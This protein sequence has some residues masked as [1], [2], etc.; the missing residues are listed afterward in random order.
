[1]QRRPRVY[2]IATY[3]NFP[4]S[5]PSPSSEIG[6]IDSRLLLY[7]PDWARRM[8][9]AALLL[10]FALSAFFCAYLLINRTDGEGPDLLVFVLSV[11]QASAAG[12]VFVLILFY[13][14]RDANIDTLVAHSDEFLKKHMRKALERVSVPDLRIERF[15]VRDGGAKDVFGHLF[16]MEAGELRVPVWIGLNV[17]RLFVIYYLAREERADFTARV[18]EIFR[19]TF[20]GA[21]QAGFTANCEEAVVSGEPVLSIWLCADTHRDLLTNPSEKLFWSQDVAM[22]TESFVRTALRNGLNLRTRCNPA[23]L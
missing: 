6:G 17:H 19:F 2:R 16:I 3:Y 14:R 7:I 22:M 23:P 5:E 13:S 9:I 4:M 1:M 8:S 10:L 12:L 15:A 21:M 18:Q 20:G 11:V